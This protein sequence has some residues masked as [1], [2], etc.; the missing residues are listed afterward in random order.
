MLASDNEIINAAMGA[1]NGDRFR[2]LWN[3]DT[4]TY[5]S[6]SEA[7]QALC[8]LL[9]FW[10][11]N[12]PGRIEQLF[13]QS[14]LMRDKWE[15]QDYRD[16]TI[17][18]AIKATPETW[19]MLRHR[20]T[21]LPA[22]DP[23]EANPPGT[24]PGSIEDARPTKYSDDA[25]ADTFSARHKHDFVYVDQWGWLRWTGERWQRVPDPVVMGF[26]R[27][28]CRIQSDLCKHDEELSEKSRPGL[29]RSIASA[30]TVAAVTALAKTDARHYR[31]A[32]Q[33]DAD[34]WAF[35][36]PGGTIDLRTGKLRTHRREDLITKI[37]H[38]T[39]RGE[40]PLWLAFLDR[41]TD[42][43]K[44]LQ[45]YLQR[46]A[47]YA[48]VGDPSE[49]CLDFFYGDGGNGK[50]TFLKALQHIFGEYSTTAQTETFLE[51]KGDRHPTDIAKLA[52]ARLVVAQEVDEG[53][54]WNEARLKA[55]TGR[56][57][58]TARF[59]RR[60]LFD[61]TPQFTLIIAGNNKP[62]LKTVDEAWRR[63]FHLVPFDV[64]IPKAEQNPDLKDELQT[65]AD[66]ILGWA[67]EGCLQWQRERLSPPE[68]VL[69][70]TEEYLADEDTFEMWLSECCIRGHE[71]YEERTKW[72]YASHRRW[73][74]SRG[75]GPPGT[76]KFSQRLKKHG[77]KD[78][79]R[80]TGDRA[81]IFLGLQLTDDERNTVK[82]IIEAR[83]QG[84]V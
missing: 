22:G 27:Q 52:G 15:R 82:A 17:N 48:L 59:M 50:G 31:E 13:R 25:L 4:S 30:K 11:G 75:E 57:E 63:R 60:D 51:A 37:A 42:G 35:N 7:D 76:K 23:G 66:G 83:E 8:N 28:V 47:G 53:Q 68:V 81:R 36:T 74:E 71:V 79:Q 20:G 39:P 45:D 58:M 78:D 77:F 84:N 43:S 64:T 49:E 6:H 34:L 19:G 9:A 67:V 62:V 70:A 46:L 5:P 72:L 80:T 18:N 29:A 40:C 56:D 73:T 38:A 24:D 41:V 61:F 33:F 1:S 14:G 55:L 26:A 69:A 2:L 21:V 12:D 3:G 16:R 32:S 65:E 44:D 54:H 10:T